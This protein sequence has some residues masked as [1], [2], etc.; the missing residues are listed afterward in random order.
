MTGVQTCALP[1]SNRVE[2]E[3]TLLAVREVVALIQEMYQNGHEP[4]LGQIVHDRYL[5]ECRQSCTTVLEKLSRIHVQAAE[6]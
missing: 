3:E 4:I 2:L 5:Q 1:I 6:T